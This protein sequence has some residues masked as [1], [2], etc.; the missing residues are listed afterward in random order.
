MPAWL[1]PVELLGYLAS[2]LVVASLAMTSVVRLR[3]ISLLG[4]IAFVGYGVML[5]SV[6]LMI[7]NSAVAALNIWFLRKEFAGGRDLG[8][9]PIAADAP[10]LKDFLAS[11]GSDIAHRQPDFPGL[12]DDAVAFLLTRDGLPA[13]A[14]VGR[15][16]G[17]TLC[18]DLDYVMQ[19]YRDTRLGRWV[20]GDGAKVLRDAGFNRVVALP[21]SSGH[22]AYLENVG[23]A[24]E[25]ERYEKSL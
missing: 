12:S 17:S 21:G 16:E 25:G 6:P 11:H 2:V 1:Q 15:R 5:G 24:R 8:A 10:F 14:L 13:G 18:L 7:T 20:Y 4:A 23:F 22:S 9:V 3:I 19:A